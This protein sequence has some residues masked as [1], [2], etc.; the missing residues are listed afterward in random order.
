MRIKFKI[1]Y[2]QIKDHPVDYDT[3][4]NYDSSSTSG[5]AKKLYSM[6]RNYFY[7]A[8]GSGYNFDEIFQ[9][10][11]LDINKYYQV[12]AYSVTAL[13]ATI[14]AK[15]ATRNWSHAVHCIFPQGSLRDYFKE[16]PKREMSLYEWVP[17]SGLGRSVIVFGPPEVDQELNLM[18][19]KTSYSEIIELPSESALEYFT[20]ESI[21]L[22][23]KSEI[24][25][26]LGPFLGSSMSPG[27]KSALDSFKDGY[28]FGMWC[29]GSI[30][31][32]FPGNPDEFPWSKRVYEIQK[33]VKD[34]ME[35]PK[36]CEYVKYLETK[37]LIQSL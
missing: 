36:K 34:I 26:N 14:I 18:N 27:L 13:S 22:F 31:D 2:P 11:G 35:S 3:I 28:N 37:R 8:S 30:E 29:I 17:K 1:L 25:E 5:H 9:D 10:S 7:R 32:R 24:L 33:Q 4:I 6:Y 15:E 19:A 16:D 23:S 12:S 20:G 21:F